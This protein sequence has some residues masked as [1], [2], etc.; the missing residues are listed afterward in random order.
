MIANDKYMIIKKKSQL[1]AYAFFVLIVLLAVKVLHDNDIEERENISKQ[2]SAAIIKQDK[3]VANVLYQTQL[4]E[5]KRGN[6]ILRAAQEQS[7]AQGITLDYSEFIVPCKI[8][9]QAPETTEDLIP[10]E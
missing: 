6:A 7:G 3:E 9:I 1:I 5:C 8:A 4:Q 10:N 2:T